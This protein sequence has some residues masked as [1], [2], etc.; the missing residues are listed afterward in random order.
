[1]TFEDYKRSGDWQML[2]GINL[3]CPHLA[4]YTMEGE[5]KRDFPASISFQSSWWQ[6][7]AALETYFARGGWFLAQGEPVC[8]LLVL[9]PIESV[10]GYARMG[11]F[12]VLESSDPNIDILE[13]TYRE[14]FQILAGAHIEFDYGDEGILNKYG[15]VENDCLRIGNC[16]YKKILLSGVRTLRFGTLKLL[17]EFQKNGGQVIIVE[18]P[19]AYVDGVLSEQAERLMDKGD[20]IPF[21]ENSMRNICKDDECLELQGEGAEKIFS[22]LKKNQNEKYI[23]LL[24]TDSQTGY[25]RISLVLQD[26]EIAEIWDARSGRIIKYV[27][28]VQTSKGKFLNL[29]FQPG[30]EKFIRIYQGTDFFDYK[31]SEENV[32]V[33]DD[34][35]AEFDG[36]RF[37]GDVLKLD[38]RIRRCAGFPLRGGEMLQPWFVKKKGH[39]NECSMLINTTFRF[40]VDEVPHDLRIAFEYEECIQTIAVNGH[41]LDGADAGG[42][43][44]ACF[45]TRRIPE[46]VIRKGENAVTFHIKYG[47]TMGLE[48]V[49]LLGM[50]GVYQDGTTKKWTLSHLPERLKPGDIT[51]QGLP[52]Y[53][54]KVSYHLEKKGI[55]RIKD[56]PYA[57]AC[58]KILGDTEEVLYTPP[59][60]VILKNPQWMEIILTRRNT[61]GPLHRVPIKAY[62]YGPETFLTEGDEWKDSPV[63]IEQGLMGIPEMQEYD[64]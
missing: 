18:E 50:F 55:W 53:S 59:Y 10:W 2:F 20:F 11:A 42:W 21:Q 62:A 16:C 41:I 49:Y 43:I 39:V 1:M 7:Y 19:P 3:R 61:F 32:M 44:D 51:Y 25:D 58:V 60:D 23:M 38:Q 29:K 14:T 57:G 63:L 31:L 30:E 5:G 56:V 40:Y 13:K 28:T 24:N 4:W 6:E 36:E 47:E 45:S 17:L 15:T 54:G 26:R 27:P 9:N 48:A 35:E 34:A 12:D 33:L 46:E 52:F 8:N 37:F 22:R 64:F